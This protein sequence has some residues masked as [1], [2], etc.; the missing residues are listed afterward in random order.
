MPHD[1]TQL[2]RVGKIGTAPGALQPVFNFQFFDADQS[3]SQLRRFINISDQFCS[4][5]ELAGRA[6]FWSG[7]LQLLLSLCLSTSP[8]TQQYFRSLAARETERLRA[9]DEAAAD[10]MPEQD[11]EA[12]SRFLAAYRIFFRFHT[13]GSCDPSVRNLLGPQTSCYSAIKG[14]IKARCTASDDLT[15]MSIGEGLA[16]L[17]VSHVVGE[18]SQHVTVNQE[19]AKWL[20]YV[21]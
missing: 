11:I 19:D 6:R 8:Q 14:Y 12:A 13:E 21:S 20:H 3:I 4:S 2:S 5:I 7:F 15:A 10:P 16:S 18:R 9:Q 1:V 17:M